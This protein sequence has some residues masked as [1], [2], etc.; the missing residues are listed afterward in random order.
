MWCVGE[1][2]TRD[3]WPLAAGKAR[4]RATPF[5][6][7]GDTLPAPRRPPYCSPKFAVAGCLFAVLGARFSVARS[8]VQMTPVGCGGVVLGRA[9]GVGIAARALRLSFGRVACFTTHTAVSVF[10]IFSIT[11]QRTNLG[12][13]LAFNVESCRKRSRRLPTFLLAFIL[14]KYVVAHTLTIGG[15]RT[16]R[17][18]ASITV[19]SPPCWLL[20]APVV[21]LA[22]PRLV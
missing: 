20:P 4:N 5:V 7:A 1:S 6:G 19:A 15:T 22:R 13:R 18:S 10:L 17:E 3:R 12:V 14:N 8:V 9:A 2:N 16:A 21:P 11:Y